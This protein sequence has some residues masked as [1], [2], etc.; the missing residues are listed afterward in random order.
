MTPIY[1][2]LLL[3]SAATL[4]FEVAL[5]RLFALA[6]GHHFA[7]MAVSLALLGAG[8]SGT[9]LSRRSPS[10]QGLRRWV[11]ASALLFTLTVPGSYLVVNAL[12]FDAY[13]IAWERVQLLW[14]A[15]YYLA[16]TAPFFFS[17][18]AV[19]AALVTRPEETPRVYGANLFGS[20]LGPP[21]ALLALA[22]VGGPGTVFGV[23][24]LGSL[25]FL[26]L[27]WPG[28][29]ARSDDLSRAGSN[30][31]NRYYLTI[32]G[33]LLALVC[34]LLFLFPPAWADMRLT[35]YQS[36][37]Q[38]LLYPDSR[39]AFQKWNAFSRVDVIQSQ[40]IRSAPGLSMAY[41]G[42][43]PAQVGLTVDGQN[44]S[45]ITRVPASEAEFADYL[46][47]A[48][49]YQMRP[50]ADVLVVEPGGGLAVLTALRGGARSVTVVHG[51]PAVASAV[52]NWGGDLYQDPRVSVVVDDPRS[53]LRREAGRFDV[54]I[55]PLADS[56]RPV[57]A[58]A[59]ALA[60]EYRY[61][62]E[63]FSEL[64]DHLEPDGLLVAERWLQLPPTESLRLWGITLE[65]L[66]WGGVEDPGTHLIALRSFQTSLMLASQRPFPPDELR[67]VQDFASARQYDLIWTPAL[68]SVE[69]PILD[70]S[71]EELSRLGVNRYN[72]VSGAPYFRTF[73]GLVETTNPRTFY[74]DYPYAVAP[75]TDDRPFFF[76]FFKWSQTPQVIAALGKTWQPFGGS[77]YLVLVLLL[78][79]VL[80]LSALLILLPLAIG[81]QGIR[82]SGKRGSGGEGEGGSGGAKFTVRYLLYF[83]LLGL[84]FLFVEIPLLQRFIVYLRQPTYAFATVV[85][86]LLVASGLGSHFL[87]D[88]IWPPLGLSILAGLALAYPLL[89]P[90]LFQVTFGLPLAGRVIVTALSLTPL[91]LLMGTP[92][93]QGLAV[94]RQHTPGLLAW[95]WAVNGCASVVS[96]VLAPMVAIGLGFQVVM[97]IGA[98]AYLGAM[99]S[100]GRLWG[101]SIIPRR[102]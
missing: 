20:G 38:A 62:I 96:A 84:G 41:P 54:I 17:G 18:L 65:A 47:P 40:G 102:G 5:T 74:A 8:A 29:Q 23:A 63:A 67:Q 77:G 6:Q 43:P 53:Y 37:S 89:I 44:L 58:G 45:P 86:A 13:R 82:E 19:G 46:P 33:G 3:L 32:S 91:G 10:R 69:R 93:P 70:L 4:A 99:L 56:F 68:S 97:L 49:A 11:A 30:D 42:G 101:L 27:V 21:L 34:G 81:N 50:K 94:A 57:T 76:H 22:A 14:L 31:L 95:I 7:F 24:W 39:I 15:L 12:P 92:F 1:L 64:Y 55:A 61:T 85:G 51:N 88:R 80:V 83:L 75:P 9:F 60:E 100:L 25:A 2:S 87:A 71:Q 98:A 26:I 73:A 16:L 79:L 72:V 48:L 52:R 36:L 78:V 90:P 28:R 66:R 35:P 59:Y